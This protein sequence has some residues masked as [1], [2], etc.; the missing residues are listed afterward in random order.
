MRY[1]GQ[2]KINE[3]PIF[4]TFVLWFSHVCFKYRHVDRPICVFFF[5]LSNGEDKT[6]I[7]VRLFVLT[8]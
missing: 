5:L 7:G 4:N 1:N 2:C 6:K 8:H 3:N